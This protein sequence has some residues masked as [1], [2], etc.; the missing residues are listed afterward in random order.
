V[1]GVVSELRPWG[2]VVKFR[3]PEGATVPAPFLMDW[4]ERLDVVEENL[5]M[6]EKWPSVA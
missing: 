3:C 1:V 2:V 6:G 5:G 4:R